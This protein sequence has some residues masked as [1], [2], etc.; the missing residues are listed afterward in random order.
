MSKEDISLGKSKYANLALSTDM[1]IF[2]VSK[3]NAKT[4]RNLSEKY[5]SILLVKRT[6][7]PFK[8]NKYIIYGFNR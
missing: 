6:S 7:E 5:F 3:G 4:C 8:D 1:L 2:S